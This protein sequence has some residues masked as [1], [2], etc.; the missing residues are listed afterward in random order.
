VAAERKEA[1]SLRRKAA[2][3]A[4][5]FGSPVG[6]DAL[7]VLEDEFDRE[8]IMAGDPYTT[9]YNLGRRDVVVY[10]RQMIRLYKRENPS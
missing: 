10:I 4:N 7:R 6:T 8:N 5:L 9:A 2:L 1:A 3:L